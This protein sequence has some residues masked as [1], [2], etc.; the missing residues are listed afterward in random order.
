MSREFQLT[1]ERLAALVEGSL[2]GDERA[3]VLAKLSESE[4]WQDVLAGT[5]AAAVAES[6]NGNQAT[7][8]GPRWPFR[9]IWPYWAIA[10]TLVV[11]LGA[12][13]LVRTQR[14]NDD[15]VGRIFASIR[16]PSG[17]PPQLNERPWSAMRGEDLVAGSVAMAA[18]VGVLSVDI[19]LAL[20]SRDSTV[21]L[22]VEELQR[23]ASTL[24]GSGPV[25]QLYSQVARRSRDDP[26]GAR[27]ALQEATTAVSHLVREDVFR[28]AVSLEA[29]RAARL[30]GDTAFVRA[31]TSANLLTELTSVLASE[32]TVGRQLPQL[33]EEVRAG[34]V[35]ADSVL[36][37]LTRGVR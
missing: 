12:A 3:A 22:R 24:P 34:R 14:Q 33:V 23:L 26:V 30:A 8:G 7:A 36:V 35:S 32:S 28:L 9:R 27:S 1:E 10:A 16:L 13:M 11:V 29:L 15:D 19:G 6:E 17:L 2:T 21:A 25:V 18:R 5:I 31:T 4:E 20:S 37:L